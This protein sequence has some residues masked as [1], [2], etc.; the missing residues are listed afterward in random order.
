ME[1][2][3]ALIRSLQMFKSLCFSFI[4]WVRRQHLHKM[5]VQML[6]SLFLE[7]VILKHELVVALQSCLIDD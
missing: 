2:A 5:E 6:S 1:L 7:A 4:F 3:F